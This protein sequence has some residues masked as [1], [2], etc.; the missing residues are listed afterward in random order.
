MTGSSIGWSTLGKRGQGKHPHT[1]TRTRIHY[2]ASRRQHLLG[3]Q[4]PLSSSPLFNLVLEGFTQALPV[5]PAGF[6]TSTG[7]STAGNGSIQRVKMDPYGQGNTPLRRRCGLHLLSA[8][9]P[10]SASLLLPFSI[11]YYYYKYLSIKLFPSHK[12]VREPPS[13]VPG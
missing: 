5:D 9:D 2:R 12:A 10:A 7:T 6:S 1:Q 13:R 3:R 8:K 11:Q 4:L